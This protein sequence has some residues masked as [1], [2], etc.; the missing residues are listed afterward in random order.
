MSALLAVV[1]LIDVIVIAF[2]TSSVTPS[3]KGPWNWTQ[4]GGVDQVAECRCCSK[5][6]ASSH[7]SRAG[8]QCSTSFPQR[9]PG[10]HLAVSRS[11]RRQGW[12]CICPAQRQRPWQHP[13]SLNQDL[14]AGQ[15]PPLAPGTPFASILGLAC[16]SGD[17]V[18]VAKTGSVDRRQ[19]AVSGPLVSPALGEVLP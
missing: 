17:G 6:E 7:P 1:F 11:W 15:E 16:R 12:S 18:G 8:G 9:P 19:S 13:P 3:V 14:G 10:Q 2:R 5:L 4:R